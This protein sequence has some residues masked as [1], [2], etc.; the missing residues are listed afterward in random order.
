MENKLITPSGQHLILCESILYK[1]AGIFKKHLRWRV[2]D[3][4]E[5]LLRLLNAKE[6]SALEYYEKF[7]SELVNQSNYSSQY[8]IYNNLHVVIDA[9]LTTNESIYEQFYTKKAAVSK[10]R[11]A[12]GS[13][14]GRPKKSKKDKS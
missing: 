13:M 10:I 3:D 1:S 14:G 12:T 5:G 2:Y 6:W 9:G 8:D 11:S 7:Y 4:R